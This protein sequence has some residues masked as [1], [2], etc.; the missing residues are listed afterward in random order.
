MAIYL[1]LTFV[2]LAAIMWLIVTGKKRAPWKTILFIVILLLTEFTT[3]GLYL[4]TLIKNM[5]QTP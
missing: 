5:P 2:P 4:M 3:Q 1:T